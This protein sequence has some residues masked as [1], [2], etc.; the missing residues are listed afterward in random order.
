MFTALMID[1]PGIDVLKLAYMFYLGATPNINPCD[2][3]ADVRLLTAEA[4][5]C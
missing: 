1:A 2:E 3:L 4:N 5:L